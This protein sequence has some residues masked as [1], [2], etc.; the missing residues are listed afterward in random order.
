LG[1]YNFYPQRK[2]ERLPLT[3]AK[4]RTLKA[5]E[6]PYKVADYDGLYIN[7]SKAGS[8]L[9]RFKYRYHGKEGLLSFGP[10][11]AI[12][13]AEARRLRDAARADLANGRNPATVKREKKALALGDA[14]NTFSSIAEKFMEKK[15]KDG[16]AVATLRKNRWILDIVKPDI[17]HLPIKSITA[18]VVLKSLKKREKLGHY[19]TA[20]KMRSVVGGV[21]RFAMASGVVNVDPTIALR[22]ALIAPKTKH[23][24]A[25]TDK[26]TLGKLLKALDNYS[27]QPKTRIGLK[28]LILFATRPGELRYAR[29]DEFDYK[30]RVWHIPAE[31]MKMRKE[32]HVPLSDAAIDLLEELHK[33]TGWGELL[34]PSQSS[35]KKPISENTF[36]QALR[37]MGYG[38]EQVT[39]H[40]FRATFST[41]ANESGLWHPDAIERA[42]A[43]VERNAVRRAYDR[44]VH[45]EERVKMA[46]WWAE[47]LTNL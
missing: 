47:E 8:K 11:P 26:E 3:D 38:P 9:W 35:S 5:K 37:R 23:R 29:W 41:L 7:V 27:G 12:S 46:D 30:K 2:D 6:K 33:L 28:L 21:F 1:V 20:N 34:F 44:G 18:P 25:I 16:L 22:D 15:V 31:R 36:N 10:Y 32:H 4:L 13:L 24:A 14:Q 19:D 17:G 39:S 45:W 42:I 43:H 40:G